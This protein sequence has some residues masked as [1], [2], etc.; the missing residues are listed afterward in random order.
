MRRQNLSISRLCGCTVAKAYTIYMV[1][2]MTV[3]II[4]Y[5]LSLILFNFV[6]VPLLTKSFAFFETPYPVKLHLTLFITYIV[7][8]FLLMTSHV[9]KIL[10]QPM[11]FLKKGDT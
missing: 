4:C 3:I 2:I 7:V 5:L 11:D 8:A 6:A 1:E 9:Y 10:K